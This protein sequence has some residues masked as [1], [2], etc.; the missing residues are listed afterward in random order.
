M[1]RV[2]PALARRPDLWTTAARQTLAMAPSGWWRR[3]P[4]LPLPD[5]AYL[6]FR[7]ETMYGDSAAEPGA[8]DVVAYLEWCRS[9]LRS[10]R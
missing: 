9:G 2:L 6:A 3:R 7:M 8:R 5:P 10:L 1:V 4:F